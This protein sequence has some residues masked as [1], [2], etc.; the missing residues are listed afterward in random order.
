MKKLIIFLAL[1][2][3]SC[4]T[5]AETTPTPFPETLPD[6]FL[7]EYTW[8]AGSL[9]EVYY[10]TYTIKISASTESEILFTAGYPSDENSESW[11]ETFP[12][13]EETVEKLYADLLAINAFNE[14]WQ[15]MED[16]PAGGSSSKSKITAHGRENPIP[17]FVDGANAKA[18]H[19]IYEEIE[20]LV[21]QEVWDRLNVHHQNY[22]DENGG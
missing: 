18:I 10:Y 2:L 5:P 15:Q 3:V 1:L 6:D 16:V 13:S 7:I 22:M 12:I 9:E 14:N 11:H 21:P 20:K 4:A 19:T 8:S 17:A